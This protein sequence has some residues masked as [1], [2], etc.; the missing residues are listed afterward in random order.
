MATRGAGTGM[1]SEVMSVPLRMWNVIE[2]DP[3]DSAPTVEIWRRGERGEK[4]EGT[5]R[6]GQKYNYG[7]LIV[8]LKS[9]W[10][11]ATREAVLLSKA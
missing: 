9:M 4:E 11:M 1:G 10:P 7:H 2:L 3:S 6:G 8:D 5:G